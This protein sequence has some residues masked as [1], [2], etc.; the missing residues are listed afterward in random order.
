MN[1]LLNIVKYNEVEKPLNLSGSLFILP[2]V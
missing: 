1:F 2:I